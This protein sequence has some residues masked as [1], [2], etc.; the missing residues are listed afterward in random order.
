[1]EAISVNNLSK[2]Y[3][4]GKKALDNV[5]ISVSTG[6]IFSLLG[7]N[8]AG[9]ST[10][11]N[12]LTTFL[13]PTSGLV[14]VLG[15]DV[16]TEQ[17]SVR[18][19]ISC[20]AQKVSIDDHLSLRENML[21]QSRL[22]KLDRMTATKRM[23][24][25]I[26]AFLLKEYEKHKVTAYSGGVKRRL[27][28]AMSMMSYPK[29]LFLDE[30]T[31]GMDI[32]SRKAMWEVIKTIKTQFGTTVFL[33]THYLEEADMLSDTVCI[34]KD[35]HELVQDTPEHLREHTR[36]NIV[37]IDLDNPEKQQEIVTQILNLPFVKGIRQEQNTIYANTYDAKKDF[38]TLNQ[39][40]SDKR[41]YYS[42][43]GVV[44]PS[45]DDI[46]LS[47]TRKNEGGVRYANL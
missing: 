25:L 45:L 10:L 15:H 43:I 17:N 35:G 18:A 11:I 31:A 27:D 32:E 7:P 30:P 41:I 28:I 46:F 42:S 34:M 3:A 6:E 4:S 16:I 19:D 47:L 29:I 33:T 20:V 44:I 21:F 12:I 24:A 14:S 9:K 40:L 38:Y 26:A 2:E 37:R 22:H 36:K 39:F 23:D 5:S 13:K 8:G 1:M